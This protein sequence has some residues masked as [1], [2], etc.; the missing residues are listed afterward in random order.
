MKRNR[1]LLLP[2]LRRRPK[3]A[4]F[5]IHL[6]LRPLVAVRRSIPLHLLE[7][8]A[9][10]RLIRSHPQLA[11]VRQV[12]QLQTPLHLAEVEPRRIPLRLL[13]EAQPLLQT[14]LLPK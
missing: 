1:L 14:P 3:Q 5:L 7:A 12:Q 8:A 6:L 2:L 9:A 10:P 4:E 11:V 13:A